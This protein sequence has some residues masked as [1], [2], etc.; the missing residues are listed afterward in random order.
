MIDR[1]KEI[2]RSVFGYA[3]FVSLQQNVIES[4]LGGRDTLAVM[5]TGVGSSPRYQIPALIFEGTTVVVSPL[6]SLMKDQVEQLAQFDIPAV[7]LNSSLS[8]RAYRDNVNRIQCGKAKLLYVAPET[9][10]KP[11]VLALL[12]SVT[13]PC[14]AVDEAHCISEWGPDFRPEYRQLARLREKMPTAVCVALTATATP[15]VQ[16]DMVQYLGLRNCA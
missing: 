12:E 6:V 5:P 16:R 7:L 2:L 14:L 3:R 8:S 1:A 9:L 10:L 11:N 4:V 15:K 13:V